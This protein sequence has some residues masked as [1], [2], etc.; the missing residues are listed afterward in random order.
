L[1]CCIKHH[2]PGHPNRSAYPSLGN[3][4]FVHSTNGIG[5]REGEHL[6]LSV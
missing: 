4:F 1:K 3:S 6:I 5:F 2:G